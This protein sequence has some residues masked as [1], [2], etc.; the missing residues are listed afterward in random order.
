MSNP[1]S[2]GGVVK[3]EKFCNRAEE[4]KELKQDILNKQNVLIY[5]NEV[6][7]VLDEFQEIENIKGL[8]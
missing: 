7:I 3:E 1:F 6:C 4:L 5:A 8:E 2:F